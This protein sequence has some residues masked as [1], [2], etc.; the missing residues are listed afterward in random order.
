MTGT[1]MAGGMTKGT[2]T[3]RTMNTATAMRT[4]MNMG[5]DTISGNMPTGK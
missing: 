1:L 3:T 5:T 2:G 4:G